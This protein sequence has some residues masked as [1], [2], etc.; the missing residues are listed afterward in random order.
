VDDHPGGRRITARCSPEPPL[1][2]RSREG[3]G[4]PARAVV[5]LAAYVRRRAGPQRSEQDPAPRADT[6]S[7][8]NACKGVTACKTNR[9]G[10]QGG[11]GRWGSVCERS[12]HDR[13]A[14]PAVVVIAVGQTQPRARLPPKTRATTTRVSIDPPGATHVSHKRVLSEGSEET[15][16]TCA[17]P[18]PAL[19]RG[20]ESLASAMRGVGG[21]SHAGPSLPRGSG[22]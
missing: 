22:Q 12:G 1:A 13:D 20:P 7:D 21:D 14:E 5:R 3:P 2:S 4:R 17:E 11:R 15:R 10:G 19:S 8:G 9:S 16:S 6:R 18:P